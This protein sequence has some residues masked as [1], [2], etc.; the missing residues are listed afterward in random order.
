[1]KN[2]FFGS[3]L[4]QFR[5]SLVGLAFVAGISQQPA[6]AQ[7]VF[8]INYDPSV[9]TMAAPQQALFKSAFQ[10]AAD[11]YSSQFNDPITINM[12][13]GWGEVAGGALMPG[14][15]G[16]SSTKLQPPGVGA[17]YNYGQVRTALV[18]DSKSAADATA[19]GSLGVADPTGGANF[20]MANAEAKALKLL[21]GNAAGLDGSIGFNSNSVFTFNPGA[22]AVAGAYDF[23]GV[24][25]HEISEVMGRFT[26][27]SGGALTP[28][29]LFR[30]TGANTLDLP[31]AAASGAYFSID[32][33]ATPINV[34][35]GTGGGDTG[36]W[37]GGTLDS[38]NANATLGKESDVSAGDITEMDVIGY[39][40][41][42]PATLSLV[43][44]GAAGLFLA[45][46]RFARA[47]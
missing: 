2:R 23:I 9:G 24:A 46:R 1:M 27:T 41:P 43:A 34:F 36:D 20:E 44:V 35:N 10:T 13:V 17:F 6:R 26:F 42:E 19:V 15:V 40:V 16:Q 47:C 28:L 30:Y 8:N 22:R 5:I 21:A 11:F 33:G 38:Y 32:S 25:E 31:T 18:N 14:A 37:A 39:D 4:T 29:N 12:N 7:L 45:R 3:C